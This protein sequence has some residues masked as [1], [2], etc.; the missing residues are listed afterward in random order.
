MKGGGEWAVGVK[1]ATKCRIDIFA[2]KMN[3][4]RMIGWL[5]QKS[6]TGYLM[7]KCG[8]LACFVKKKF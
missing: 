3:N 7:Y 1:V 8:L 2:L 4:K 5:L 6:Q